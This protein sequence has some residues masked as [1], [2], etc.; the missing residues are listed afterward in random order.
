MFFNQISTL[1]I[2]GWKIFKGALIIILL[3]LLLFS[4]TIWWWP[5]K[6]SLDNNVTL[7]DYANDRI[8]LICESGGNTGPDWRVV[9]YEGIKEIEYIDIDISGFTPDIMLKN[10]LY[11]YRNS[12]FLFAGK[13]SSKEA[14]VFFV[15]EWHI[16]GNIER[17][18]TI[19]PYPKKY[20]N[21]FE[22]RM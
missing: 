6:R 5:I 4:I 13:F 17:I 11:M 22:I 8:A 19:L 18:H 3:V 12:K 15:E 14:A 10:P 21:I 2:T 7:S 16:V 9:Q 1:T 20:F